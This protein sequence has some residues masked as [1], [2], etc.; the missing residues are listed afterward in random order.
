MNA[1]IRTRGDRLVAAWGVPHPEDGDALRALEAAAALHA[2]VPEARVA[3]ERVPAAAAEGFDGQL[4]ESASPGDTVLGPRVLPLVAHAVDVVAHPSGGF[5]VLHVDPHAEPMPRRFDTPLVA[6]V[7][8]LARLRQEVDAVRTRGS[9]RRHI[10]I[11]EAGIGK[12]RL[13]RE[14]VAHSSARVLWARCTSHAGADPIGD[15]VAQVGSA[16]ALLGGEADGA[17]VAAVLAARGGVL[18][19]EERWALRRLL[20]T[21]GRSGPVVV[22]LDDLQWANAGVL[23][24]VDYL[25]GWARAPILVLGLA[26]PELLD[27]RP[28]VEA[29][30]WHM[31][32]L[33]ADDALRLV[34]ALPESAALDAHRIASVVE[35]SEGNPLYIEQI[36]AW[37]SEERADL[38]PPTV[39]LL[40][41]MRV[42]GLPEGE[43]RVVERAAVVG[44]E[45]WRGGVEAAS[46]DDERAGVAPALMALV[47][48]RLVHP[49]PTHLEGEDGF[50]FHHA[51]IRDVVYGGLAGGTRARLH[52]A[53]ARS[54]G[55]D[56]AYDALAG[57]HLERAAA[58]DPALGVEAA[59]R[60][61]AAG[62][63]ALR[64]IDAVAAID[65]L[66]RAASFT[67]ESEQRREL[68][69]GVATA[70]KFAGESARADALL[71]DVAVRAS[72]AGDEANALRARIEQVWPRLGRGALGVDDALTLLGQAASSFQ[73]AGDDFAAAR[74]W[75]ITAAVDG[76]YLLRAAACEEAEH[77]ARALYER[78]G[79]TSGA[80]DVRL[81]GAAML[82]P[83]PVADAIGLCE[84]LLAEAETPVWASFIQPFL[85][86]LLAMQGRFEAARA[87]LEAARVGRAE[88]ADPGTLDT[89][90]A[91]F[92]AEVE[93][94]AGELAAAERILEGAAGRLRSTGDAEWIATN[95]AVLAGLRLRQERDREALALADA[96]LAGVPAA[97]LTV[98]TI[99]R[100]ARA[101][102]LARLDRHE[103]ALAEAQRNVDE[104][105]R[106]DALVEQARARAALAEVLERSGRRAEADERRAEAAALLERKGDVVG[107]HELGAG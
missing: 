70:I 82:G 105:D 25:V 106:A 47:R 101:V 53:V 8:E 64:R 72:A 69:W 29:D 91:L 23:D 15:L 85:A 32:A 13:A 61:G 77:R 97:H 43:R 95:G 49:A 3:I 87:A 21:L 100:R 18:W 1:T 58:A 5:R 86:V 62:M 30:A 90:W 12:T 22:V 41:A 67:S 104:L 6:R 74:A 36:V 76:V 45:F 89:S 51:L 24:L 98:S 60:L 10:V 83:T 17:N 93:V 99:G 48:R 71:E 55:Q 68:D 73:R 31:E 9:A 28:D 63:R 56:A 40:I 44:T 7:E 34:R 103:E 66:S 26:R 54:L 35:A 75:D 92:A 107:L 78:A 38:V 27:R 88:Y 39:D 4:L 81:A 46:P 20:E 42:E 50:R 33:D 102:A 79:S 14:F 96:A 80:A 11:G 84:E 16:D 57:H 2:V 94:R 19:T 59:R 37:S 65:L 52:A